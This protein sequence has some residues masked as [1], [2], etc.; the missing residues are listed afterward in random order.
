[1]RQSTAKSKRI[2]LVIDGK[3]ITLP[4]ALLARKEAALYAGC[5]VG[6]LDKLRASD[7]SRR[8]RGE[9]IQGPAWDRTSFGI[10]YRPGSL[11]AWLSRTSEPCGVMAS[12]RREKRRGK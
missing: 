11:D 5:S 2:E 10:R 7:A 1:M 4:P 12:R 6:L 3:V 9:S 8:M